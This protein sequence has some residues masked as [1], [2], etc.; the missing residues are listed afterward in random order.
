MYNFFLG[1]TGKI[2]LQMV[3]IVFLSISITT[4]LGYMKLYETT[5]VNSAVRIDRAARAA[6]S[7]FTLKL[8]SEY[9]PILNSS[10]TPLAIRLK[11]D[12]VNF[13]LSFRDGHDALLKE[14][15]A[16]N[17][18]AAN[19]FKFNPL[20]HELDRFATTFR[21]PDGSMPPPLSIGLGHPA[22]ANLINNLPHLG[23]VPV[24]GRMRL[25][26]L[27]PIQTV[28]GVLAGALAVD[29]GWVDDLV[30][31]KEELQDQF[32]FVAIFIIGLAAIFCGRYVAKA[33]KPLRELASFADDLAAG[34]PHSVVPHKYLTDEIGALAQGLERVV[35]L[36]DKLSNLAYNDELTG[37]G[38]QSQYLS[39]LEGILRADPS[40]KYET[41]L[42]HLDIDSFWRVNNTFGQHFGYEVLKIVA[43]RIK[44]V[45]GET[46]KV[47]RLS[48]EHFTILA[49]CKGTAAQAT[50]LVNGIL[51]ALHQPL[52]IAAVEVHITASIGIYILKPGVD[53]LD[54]AHRNADLALRKS[55]ENSHDQF[56]F[57]QPEMKDD[58]QDEVRMDR[59][60]QTAIKNRELQL[61][62]QPQINPKNNEWAGFEALVRW[63]HPDEG[64]IPPNK[65][66][67]MAEANGRIVDLGALVL[68]L[69]CEQAAKWKRERFHFKHIAIN[70]SPIQLWQ[71]NFVTVLKDTLEHHSLAGKDI[72]IEITENL[73][74][75]S[76]S[77]RI[78]EQL[79]AIRAIGIKISLDDFGAGYSSL[80]YLSRLPIDQL[81]IDRSLIVGVDSDPSKQAVLRSISDLAIGL[82]YDIMFEGVE[83]LEEVKVIREIG[84]GCIQGFFFAKPAPEHLIPNI[85]KNIA[86]SKRSFGH[87]SA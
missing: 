49:E 70:V 17:Q 9:E 24:L 80:G 71:S 33:L 32:I 67:P 76:N 19:L 6:A 63:T 68:D 84:I 44:N 13:S 54:L 28:D 56:V 74:V 11:G 21:K 81:K 69:A 15:G 31:A 87:R 79:K 39:D 52:Q 78:M 3:L 66:I 85:V 36:Q 53:S 46:S 58:M 25:A 10:G 45:A 20:T 16:V 23:E 41:A 62:F 7:I 64:N 34:L 38:N 60:L 30:T 73:F 55:K 35:T 75:D 48:S 37:L 82:D 83:T 47:S 1:L 51:E 42:L 18:G 8:A 14:I 5:E 22:F 29:V 12:T 59:L 86:E 65:F 26:Y 43:T 50:Q 61:H 77:D 27:I 40:N 72:Y 4:G 57:F 2:A